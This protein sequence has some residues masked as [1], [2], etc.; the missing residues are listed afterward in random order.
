MAT[1]GS[2]SQCLA[3]LLMT[4]LFVAGA[5]PL[6]AARELPRDEETR[7]FYFHPNG[8][9]HPSPGSVR[10]VWTEKG[11]DRPEAAFVSPPLDADLPIALDRS[12]RVHL[13]QRLAL[14]DGAFE[15]TLRITLLDR[16]GH[17][18]AW[19]GEPVVLA[20]ATFESDRRA[21][22]ATDLTIG[23]VHLPTPEPDGI[24][25][26]L[27]G[28][29]ATQLVETGGHVLCPGPQGSVSCAALHGDYGWGNIRPCREAY[30]RSVPAPSA[31]HEAVRGTGAC[32]EKS[33]INLSRSA[34]SSADDTARPGWWAAGHVARTAA[35]ETPRKPTPDEGW[36]DFAFDVTPHPALAA[37][38]GALI[39]PAGHRLRIEHTLRVDGPPAVSAQRTHDRDARPLAHMA[40]D[41]ATPLLRAKL[42]EIVLGGRSFPPVEFDGAAL[43]RTLIDGQDFEDAD[44]L[45]NTESLAAYDSTWQL[46]SRDAPSRLEV[47]VLSPPPV[48]RTI[49]AESFDA[50]KGNWSLSGLWHVETGCLG[51]RSGNASLQFNRADT[52]TYNTTASDGKP[53]RALGGASLTIDLTE[54]RHAATLRFW[55]RFDVESYSGAFDT[56]RVSL[57]CGTDVVKLASW[58][59]RSLSPTPWLAEEFALDACLGSHATLHFEFD[60]IDGVANDHGGWAIDD[61]QVTAV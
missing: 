30:W 55:H 54:Y 13:D 57:R 58:D 28:A 41:A 60:S 4:I 15:T 1:I 46:G 18:V 33:A 50:G 45:A 59:S 53:G 17:P 44:R 11:D 26:M 23:S 32:D 10:T 21:R 24:A 7:T 27:G 9:M 6:A 48:E 39:V 31:A 8:A 12:F 49:L 2:R 52:C 40:L 29:S 3:A 36:R 42:G 14:R 38:H 20:T 47:R 22:D 19:Q 16:A 25:D 34:A 35:N 43:A 61:I 37:E 51:A 5:S 56:M